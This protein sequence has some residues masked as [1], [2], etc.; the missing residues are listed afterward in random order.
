[1][2]PKQKDDARRDEEYTLRD[3]AGGVNADKVLVPPAAAVVVVPLPPPLVD[4]LVRSF[5]LTRRRGVVAETMLLRVPRPLLT[6][7]PIPFLLLV[8]LVIVS[9]VIVSTI[10]AARVGGI[11]AVPSLGSSSRLVLTPAPLLVV[12]FVSAEITVTVL[13]CRAAPAPIS[14]PTPATA[15]RTSPSSR[16]RSERGFVKVGVPVDPLIGSHEGLQRRH[17][18]G[19]TGGLLGGNRALQSLHVAVQVAFEKAKA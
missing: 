3:V 14:A 9:V 12:T 2:L 15:A 4:A 1:M 18:V 8:L 7:S 6:Q 11:G 10:I 5:V 19:Q 16:S 13:V 17:R